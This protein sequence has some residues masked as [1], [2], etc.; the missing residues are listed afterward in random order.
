MCG[1]SLKAA[2]AAAM[3][4]LW[5]SWLAWKDAEEATIAGIKVQRC[6]TDA[7]LKVVSKLA[8]YLGNLRFRQSVPRAAITDELQCTPRPALAQSRLHCPR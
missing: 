5:E 6:T 3:H 1:D 8:N 2:A 4:S 7:A